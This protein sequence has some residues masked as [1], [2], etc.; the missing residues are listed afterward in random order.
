MTTC[1]PEKPNIS[2]SAHP[3][4]RGKSY[5]SRAVRLVLAFLADH[6]GCRE[7]RIIVD[8]ENAPSLRMPM[9]VGAVLVDCW[10]DESGRSILRRV[11]AIPH[12]P[13]G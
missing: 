13:A 5:V 7:A 6:T 8:S 9:A 1:L 10:T 12:Q 11:V 2:H 3:E 4:H